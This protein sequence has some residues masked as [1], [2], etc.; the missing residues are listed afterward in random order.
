MANKYIDYFT[1]LMERLETVDSVTL[2]FNSDKEASLWRNKMYR[3]RGKI[4]GAFHV[5]RLSINGNK[6]IATKGGLTT[7]DK[8][9]NDALNG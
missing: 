8:V 5:V 6:V 3:A 4:R 2:E 9:V 1:R 7:D